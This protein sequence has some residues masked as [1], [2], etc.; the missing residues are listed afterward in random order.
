MWS[1]PGLDCTSLKY[2]KTRQAKLCQ[3]FNVEPDWAILKASEFASNIFTNKNYIEK[4]RQ[5]RQNLLFPLE[6]LIQLIIYSR[7]TS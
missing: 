6:R 4:A 3:D 1:I 2:L 5:E 7:T